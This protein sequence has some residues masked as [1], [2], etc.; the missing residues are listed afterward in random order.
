M[1]GEKEGW[2]GAH[3]GERK[4]ETRKKKGRAYTQYT[5]THPPL[6]LQS[7]VGTQKD[8]KYSSMSSNV[9]VCA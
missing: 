7:G 4:G 5:H 1:R 2:V 6:S 3:V 9:P 8:S